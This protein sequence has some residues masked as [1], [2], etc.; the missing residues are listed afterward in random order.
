MIVQGGIRLRLSVL[1]MFTATLIFSGDVCYNYLTVKAAM[2]TELYNLSDF[3]AT[4]LKKSLEMPS[5]TFDTN[6]IQG[7]INATM[8]NEQVYA[9]VVRERNSQK[10]TFQCTTERRTGEN[11]YA[12]K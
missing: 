5:W 7:I 10:L 9:V 1:I 3:M 4:Q 12:K 2:Q 11:T 8:L 6:A